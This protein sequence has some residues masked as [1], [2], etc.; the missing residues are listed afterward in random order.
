MIRKHLKYCYRAASDCGIAVHAQKRMREL[1]ITYQ[2]STPQ[3][4]ADSFWFWNCENIPEIL[5]KYIQDL[6]IENP[7]DF[8]GWGLSKENAIAIINYKKES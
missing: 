4:I 7:M 1:G 5:P 6:E 8:I 3:S 2:H